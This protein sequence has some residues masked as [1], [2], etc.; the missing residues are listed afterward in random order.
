MHKNHRATAQLAPL[1]HFSTAIVG[2]G[3]APGG[4]ENNQMM[5][6]MDRVHPKMADLPSLEQL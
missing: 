3:L 5:L 6:S 2:Q 1:N 4:M